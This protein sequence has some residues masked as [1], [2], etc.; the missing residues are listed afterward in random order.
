M[1]RS[2]STKPK[3]RRTGRLSGLKDRFYRL[4]G[5][6]K[7]LVF[8]AVFAAVGGSTYF[9]GFGHADS[10]IK[11]DVNYCRNSSTW[12]I[13]KRGDKGGCVS[14]LQSVLKYDHGS[15]NV[16]GSSSLAVD[17]AFGADTEK[18]VKCFQGVYDLSKDGVVGPSTWSMVYAACV[19]LASSTNDYNMGICK[20][21]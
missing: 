4:N 12:R 17:G 21:I 11:Y 15:R 3:P 19:R 1:A 16:C 14:T 13:T 9:L 18:K 20:N 7:A 5:P 6:M 10:N 8:V 2:S